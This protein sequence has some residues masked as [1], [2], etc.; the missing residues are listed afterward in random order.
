[1]SVFRAEVLCTEFIVEYNLPIACADHAAPLFRKLFPDSAIAKKYWY[2]RTKTCYVD[3]TLAK[4]DAQDLV[5][6]M[7]K[8]V[9]SI[10]TV[11]SNDIGA[12]KR[13]AVLCSCL[14]FMISGSNIIILQ[15]N[16][17]NNINAN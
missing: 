4:F 7:K 6:L 10:A 5:A 2:G 15:T 9:F 13:Q 17:I 8:R 1:L 14:M 12:V 3:E 11:G 16:N